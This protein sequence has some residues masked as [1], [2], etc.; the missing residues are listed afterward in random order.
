MPEFVSPNVIKV[1]GVW[2][3]E[4][5]PREDF[6]IVK[7]Y[8]PSNLPGKTIIVGFIDVPP[9]GATPSH[10]HGGA[11]VVAIPIEGSTLNQMNNNNP[12]VYTSG[13]FWYEAPGCHHQRS[14]N[15]GDVNAKFFAVLIVD[16]EVI[17]DGYGDI[18]VLDKEVENGEKAPSN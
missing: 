9:N 13:E 17:K 8:N 12:I 10:R 4:G 5:K 15:A 11:A 18:F 1:D 14:E 16:N 2:Q 6:K 7:T 3:I